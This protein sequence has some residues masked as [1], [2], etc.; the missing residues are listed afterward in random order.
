MHSASAPLRACAFLEIASV[1]KS[2]LLEHF[3]ADSL[4]GAASFKSLTKLNSIESSKL[5]GIIKSAKIN[6]VFVQRLMSA[7]LKRALHE[8]HGVLV[9]EAI[10]DSQFG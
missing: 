6:V 7:T 10:G 3:K 4:S 9:V 5:I 2:L 1:D 8:N